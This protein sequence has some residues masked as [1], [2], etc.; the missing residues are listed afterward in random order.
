MHLAQKKTI[1]EQLNFT[2]F[3]P[4]SYLLVIRLEEPKA[5]CIFIGAFVNGNWRFFIGLAERSWA[6]LKCDPRDVDPSL[7]A[8]FGM[9]LE[10]T[11]GVA[12]KDL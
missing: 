1:L 5:V 7:G 6:L 4:V 9:R 10:A 2:K 8:F 12:A 3:Y 11:D